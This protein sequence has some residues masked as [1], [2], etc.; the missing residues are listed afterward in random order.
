MKKEKENMRK[1]QHE[2]ATLAHQFRSEDRNVIKPHEKEIL[3]RVAKARKLAEERFEKEDNKHM[4][5]YNDLFDEELQKL[6]SIV[7]R[8][9]CLVETNVPTYSEELANKREQFK[10]VKIDALINKKAFDGSREADI[11]EQVKELAK[12]MKFKSCKK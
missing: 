1:E 3:A 7:E 6:M 9:D 12:E 4:Q 5:V 8:K 11:L 2:V 10:L